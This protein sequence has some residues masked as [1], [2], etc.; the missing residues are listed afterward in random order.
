MDQ[1]VEPERRD[2][3][4]ARS[5]RRPASCATSAPE[6]DRGRT[7]DDTV[8]SAARTDVPIPA[9]PWWGRREVDVDLDDVFHHLD[10]H[11]LFKLHW[12]GKG[13]KGE[14]WRQLLDDDFLPRLDRMWREQD[15]L[16]PRAVL[17]YFPC[18]SEGNEIVVLDP[19]GP[20]DRARAARVPAPAGP[21]PDLPR[22]LLPADGPPASST[23][24]RC[25][26]SP[27][28]TR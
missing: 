5:A 21:R 19:G 27:R 28:A 8:R 17:G 3:L 1:L 14:A 24:S 10:T 4:V 11:V 25:R 23:S 2:A 22:R 18:F 15:Y 16:H 12:G 13:V 20:R 26:R 7:D 9:P 6:P